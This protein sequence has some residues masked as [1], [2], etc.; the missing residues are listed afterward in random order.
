MLAS[1]ARRASWRHRRPSKPIVKTLGML[2]VARHAGDDWRVSLVPR[3][4][5]AAA[6]KKER[7]EQRRR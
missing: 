1:G 7:H 5:P 3:P 4:T 6:T 2:I